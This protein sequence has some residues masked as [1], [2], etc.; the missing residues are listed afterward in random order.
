MKVVSALKRMCNACRIVKRGRKKVFV[1]CKN[2]RHKQR[3][4][5]TKNPY[6]AK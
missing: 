4:G 1:T 6:G 3:Q 5:R 2:G